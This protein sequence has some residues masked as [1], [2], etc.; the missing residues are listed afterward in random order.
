[1][2]DTPGQHPV[3]DTLAQTFFAAIE[4]GDIDVAGNCYHD[5]ALIWH[6]Y[7]GLSQTRAENARVLKYLSR[8]VK[9]LRYVGVERDCFAQGFVQRHRLQG[10]VRG[11]ALDAPVCVVVHVADGQIHR[12]YEYVAAADIQP[13]LQP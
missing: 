2:G 13:L 4:R 5:E 6:S 9:G 3:T 7:D 10:E 1:M 11:M 12:L 8:N